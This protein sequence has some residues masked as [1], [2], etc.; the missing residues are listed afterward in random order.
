VA[1]ANV[2]SGPL[3]KDPITGPCRHEGSLIQ[4]ATEFSDR[5]DQ[6]DGVLDGQYHRRSAGAGAVIY[7]MDTGILASHAEFTKADG[8]TRIIAAAKANR[9]RRLA[10]WMTATRLSC[11]ATTTVNSDGALRSFADAAIFR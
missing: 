4:P 9:C 2:I 10:S 11:T 6:L 8:S 5:I 3:G 7:V 1:R